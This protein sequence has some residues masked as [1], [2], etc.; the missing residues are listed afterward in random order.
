[1]RRNLSFAVLHPNCRH[2]KLELKLQYT[3]ARTQIYSETNGLKMLIDLS[4]L[5]TALSFS[6]VK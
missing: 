2:K 6:K 3:T 1:M 5:S 4:N